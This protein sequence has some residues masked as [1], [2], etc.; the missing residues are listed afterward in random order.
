MSPS[1][2]PIKTR[3]FWTWDHSTTWVLNQPGEHNCGCSNEYGRSAETFLEDY[4]RL[5]R[6]CGAHGVDGVVVWGLL[7]DIHGGADSVHRLCEVAREHDVLLLAGAG[8]N[9]YGGVYYAGDSPW[10][11]DRHLQAHPE[12]MALNAEGDPHIIGATHPY[13]PTE[14]PMLHACPSREENR[15]FAMESLRWLFETFDLGGV[16]VETGDSRVCHCTRCRE[17]RQYPVKHFSWEDMALMYPLAADAV[18]TVNRD[19][20]LITET[21]SH[22]E[23]SPDPN[24]VP[25]FGGALPPWGPACLAEFPENVIVEWVADDWLAGGKYTW[26]REGVPPAGPRRHIMRAHFA[27]LFMEPLDN[28]AIDRI[29]DLAARSASHGF[30]AI[31]IFGERSP[32]N[33]NAELNYLAFADCGSAANP[34]SDLSSFLDRLAAPLLGGPALAR[35]YVGIARLIDRPMEAETGVHRARQIAATMESAVARRWTWLANYVASHAYEAA[36]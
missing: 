12:L 26:T 11:L 25:G 14:R 3:I 2:A 24:K 28:L 36:E 8:L 4:S 1:S 15:E 29:A 13:L 21:Y 22:P 5:V 34:S 23:P 18:R 9:A 17:R 6:W 7:R 20:L 27:S 30:D 10:S 16:Q 33:A 32:F 35:E 31:S 19:A